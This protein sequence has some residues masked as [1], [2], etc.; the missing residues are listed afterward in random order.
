VSSKPFFE[1]NEIEQK[2]LAAHTKAGE[3]LRPA[4]GEGEMTIS[5]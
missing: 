5:V 1:V 4:G 3:A 2:W